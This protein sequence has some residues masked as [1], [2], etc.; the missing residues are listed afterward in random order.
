[1]SSGFQGRLKVTKILTYCTAQLDNPY[2][3]TS[4]WAPIYLVV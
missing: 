4:R 1:M 2:K 3:M